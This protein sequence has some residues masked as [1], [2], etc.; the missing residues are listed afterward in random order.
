MQLNCAFKT[1]SEA[2]NVFQAER[3]RFPVLYVVFRLDSTGL[4]GWLAGFGSS[5]TAASSVSSA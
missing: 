3:F 4:V 5:P 1:L 2:F